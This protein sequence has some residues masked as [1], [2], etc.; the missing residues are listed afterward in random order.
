[1]RLIIP[2]RSNPYIL[3][4]NRSLLTLMVKM[5]DEAHRFSRVLHHKAEKKRIVTS[6]LDLISGIGPKIKEKILS[7]LEMPLNEYR[8]F[9]RAKLCQYFD[10][11]PSIA[12]KIVSYF[13]MVD[14]GEEES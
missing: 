11:S 13:E 7:R 14:K 10:I 2:G 5:R 9:S 12:A 4:K 6:E 8:S 1:E 3:N